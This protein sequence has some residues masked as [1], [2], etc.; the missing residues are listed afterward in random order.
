[1]FW[2]RMRQSENVED[3]RSLG[4]TGLAGLGVGGTLVVA[5]ISLLMGENPLQILGMMEQGQ[6]QAAPGPAA[7]DPAR[8]F[9]AAVLGDT[10]DTW[11]QLFQANGQQYR[12]PALVLFRGQ[13]VSACGRTSS[14][15]GPFYCPGDQKVYLDL[16]FFDQLQQRF[17]APGDFAQAYVIAHE[18]GHHVQ[19]LLGTSE[20]VH[21]QQQSAGE[22]A[23]NGLSV[24][25][26][27][28]ADCYAGV[29]GHYAQQRQLLEV[30]DIEEAMAAANAIGDDTLQKQAQGHVVPDSF[31]HGSAAQRAQ[32]FRRGLQTGDMGQCDTFGAASL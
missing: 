32:W 1:M 27:L 17:G 20:R 23:A 31:T 11:K 26:E 7:N 6:Q 21:A 24:R 28:Q 4:G 16:G 19:N 14:A 5:V 25:L 2:N 15:V 13:V 29:W 30:G 12:P 18:V 8:Q 3:R 22:A 10:E 9:V